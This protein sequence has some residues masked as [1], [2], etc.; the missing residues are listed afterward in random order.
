MAKKILLN[1]TTANGRRYPAGTLLDSNA[2]NLTSIQAMGGILADV[3][4]RI[5]LDEAGARARALVARG[6][7]PAGETV[8]GIMSSAL[9]SH[10]LAQAV[11]AASDATDAAASAA[12]AQ[13]RA[14]DAY[15]LAEAAGGGG[16]GGTKRFVEPLL[17]D[18]VA[19]S[20]VA[21]IA[22]GQSSAQDQGFNQG[23]HCYDVD[24]P[25]S[26]TGG[27]VTLSL[28][29]R[30]GTIITEEFTTPGPSGGVVAGSKPGYQLTGVASASPASADLTVLLSSRMCAANAPV[31]HF[32]A[33]WV[34][35][36]FAPYSL[37]DADLAN[38]TC[39]LESP[40]TPGNPVS[41]PQGAFYLLYEA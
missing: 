28:R 39:H 18:A 5:A 6:G 20:I 41:D 21:T 13:N 3:G 22:S 4:Q 24:F 25:A 31:S 30:S 15:A 38:G 12:S 2:D 23:L 11:S 32:R 10:A 8:D 9:A 35:Q 33:A 7:G 14:D 17:F 37:I 34:S 29:S 26:W 19:G 1:T 36:G 27:V 16:G 40:I